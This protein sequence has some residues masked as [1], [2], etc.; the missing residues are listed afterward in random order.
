MTEAEWLACTDPTPMLEDLR[1]KAS[2]RK[3][4]LF[5]CACCR[6]MWSH[7]TDERSRQVVEVAERFADGRATP[8]ELTA[9]RVAAEAPLAELDVGA[10]DARR[11]MSWGE[12][13]WYADLEA[14]RL[15]T[16]AA[17]ESAT[18]PAWES[19]AAAVAGTVGIAS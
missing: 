19:A 1:G 17:V 18:D 3:L 6:A 2:D 9:A 14:R 11:A 15:A 4:R 10:E 16:R 7:L 13:D 8:A 5:A 12:A